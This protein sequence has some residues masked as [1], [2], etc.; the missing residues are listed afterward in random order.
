MKQASK[1]IQ[2]LHAVIWRTDY[3]VIKWVLSDGRSGAEP[4]GL[5][6]HNNH[7]LMQ[8]DSIELI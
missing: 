2:E 1:I 3:G 8:A 6:L 5:R 4:G 7:P